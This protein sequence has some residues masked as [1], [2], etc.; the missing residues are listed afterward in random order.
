MDRKNQKGFTLVELSIVLVVVGL[1]IGSIL[2]A[3][4][5]LQNARVTSTIN[6]LQ[7]IQSASATYNQ[8]YNALPGDD[9]QALARFSSQGVANSGGGN[10]VIGASTLSSTY[11]GLA[12]LASGNGAAESALFWSHLR[13]AGLV[14]G[15]GSQTTPPSNP[16]GGI[17][18][19]QNG[20]FLADG[21]SEGTN[22]VCLSGIPGDAATIIDQRQDDG[23]ALTG[24]IRA[25]TSVTGAAT[26]YDNSNVYV[27]CTKI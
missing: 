18:G 12:S 2:V 16:F 25:G 17:I 8:N 27:M 11:D 3:V 22:V 24:N 26:D 15:Q 4:S 13:A 20:A 21:F 9:A 19:A 6:M 1:I 10:G 23:D 7:S 14:K 5:I